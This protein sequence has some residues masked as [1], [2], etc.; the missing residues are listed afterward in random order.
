M[1]YTAAA[2]AFLLISQSA[3]EAVSTINSVD[4]NTMF[5]R[6]ISDLL[7]DATVSSSSANKW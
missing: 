5:Y 1:R 7:V 2:L 6:R 3:V 4:F